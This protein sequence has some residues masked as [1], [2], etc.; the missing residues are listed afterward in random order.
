[1]ARYGTAVGQTHGARR[2]AWRA[3][4]FVIAAACTAAPGVAAAAPQHN[5]KGRFLGVVKSAKASERPTPQAQAQAQLAA[6]D[7]KYH[8]GAVMH[9]NRTHAIY[10]EPNAFSTTL[11]YKSLING[12]L[13]DVAA[14]SGKRSNV[15]ASD[16]QYTDGSGNAA[17]SSSSAGAIVAIDPYPA[18]GCTDPGT[19]V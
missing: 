4:L 5:P 17:Y 18:S 19:T 3:A 14:D 16:V 8:G 6:G 11:T 12:F 1:M 10:W 13:S 7:L 2:R 9:S 15:Y